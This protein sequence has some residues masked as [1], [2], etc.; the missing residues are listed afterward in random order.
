MVSSGLCHS[1]L[2]TNG[3]SSK[4]SPD[5]LNCPSLF[6][7]CHLCQGYPLS[8]GSGWGRREHSRK[9]FHRVVAWK[10]LADGGL[11]LLRYGAVTLCPVSTKQEPITPR[12][13]TCSWSRGSRSCGRGRAS[14]TSVWVC[15][16]FQPSVQLPALT[17]WEVAS[18][19]CEMASLLMGRSCQLQVYY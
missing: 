9:E 2:H 1:V 3:T 5:T 13:Q 19:P 18:C 15:G 6:S 4:D 10:A 17:R 8:A 7:L 11:T 14:V 16:G 12:N